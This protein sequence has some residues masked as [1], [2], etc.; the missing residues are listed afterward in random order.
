[1]VRCKSY[2]NDEAGC[3]L[4]VALYANGSMAVCDWIGGD[5]GCEPRHPAFTCAPPPPA[6][7]PP[8]PPLP[9]CSALLAGRS[10]ALLSDSYCP[11]FKEDQAKCAAH[12]VQEAGAGSPK[13]CVH[14]PAKAPACFAGEALA[15]AADTVMAAAQ[16]PSQQ[17]GKAAPVAA[18][19]SWTP[20][21]V[22]RA[23]TCQTPPRFDR[24][25][26][27]VKTHAGSSGIIQ[28]IGAQYRSAALQEDTW[29]LVDVSSGL[30]LHNTAQGAPCSL[31]FTGFLV[32]NTSDIMNY[33]NYG[34]M[35]LFHHE[36]PLILLHTSLRRAFGSQY[37]Q[38]W[39]QEDD[40]YFNGEP[41]EFFS[42]YH[43]HGNLQHIDYVGGDV[44]NMPGVRPPRAAVSFAAAD[45][46][47]VVDRRDV[48]TAW[49]WQ[50]G[51]VYPSIRVVKRE[52]IERYSARYLDALEILF[53][54]RIYVHGEATASFCAM[55]SWCTM[56]SVKMLPG[57]NFSCA[58]CTHQWGQLKR[59][60]A[61]HH[62]VKLNR[63]DLKTPSKMEQSRTEK[64]IRN[65]RRK[66]DRNG[67]RPPSPKSKDFAGARL[68]C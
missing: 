39:V 40:A 44:P 55:W 62:A 47:G 29:A 64:F 67:V 14:D 38:Y 36:P 8:A 37:P 57:S 65:L 52:F 30:P 9:R 15:C 2:D 19:A 25:A 28:H 18:A 42:K 17:S 56:A 59:K 35:S 31:G 12:Y 16:Q 49:H 21:P 24:Q 4:R 3:L 27:V 66:A 10:N 60:N 11:A 6:Q 7:P 41:A 61:W 68:L 54:M 58:Q 33:F 13:L 26:I 22:P 32:H 5:R 45:K 43:L 1:M 53:R 63:G 46:Y 48:K 51:S 23:V 34:Y 50:R 20:A